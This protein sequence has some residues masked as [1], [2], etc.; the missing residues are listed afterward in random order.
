[1]TAMKGYLQILNSETLGSLNGEQI[2]ALQVILRNTNRL[3]HLVHDILDTS[4]LESGTMKFIPMRTEIP[5]L[6]NDVVETMQLSAI[7]KNIQIDA[8]VQDDLPEL[9]IDQERIKQVFDNIVNNAI[10]FSPNDSKIQI[11]V[12][13]GD[14][15]VQF[16]IQDIGKGI[17][18]GHHEKIFETFYQVESGMDRTF[19]GT[20]LGLTISRGIVLGHGGKIWVESTLGEGSTFKF[21]LPITPVQDVEGTFKRIDIFSI[22]NEYKEKEHQE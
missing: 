12:R 11:R 13:K 19:G 15:V 20:G 6:I 5:N 22:K 17:A 9:I 21:T 18:A 4:R 8:T 3:D 1:M 16:A 7:L 2:N 10:K 14:D